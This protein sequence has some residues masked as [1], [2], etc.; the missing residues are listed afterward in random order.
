M[1]LAIPLAVPLL[2]GIALA[3]QQRLTGYR[4][5]AEIKIALLPSEQGELKALSITAHADTG[6]AGRMS[7]LLLA[8]SFVT[9]A[10]SYGLGSRMPG[11]RRRQ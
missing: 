2:A 8:V 4:P 3:S 11:A 7:L 5:A 9:I 10:V 1:L 6:A